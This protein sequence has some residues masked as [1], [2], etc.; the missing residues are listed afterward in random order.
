MWIT[1]EVYQPPN[2]VPFSPCCAHRSLS[3]T[4]YLASQ[5]LIAHFSGVR[6]CLSSQLALI[7]GCYLWKARG[8]VLCVLAVTLTQ[9]RPAS[10]LDTMLQMA[11]WV[12]MHR[13]YRYYMKLLVLCEGDYRAS[14]SITSVDVGS[15]Y[16][17]LS[18]SPPFGCQCSFT[19]HHLFIHIKSLISL[20]NSIYLNLL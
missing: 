12:W 19:A 10:P 4:T 6:N 16:S 7:G 17:A 1:R 11:T 8:V 18:M 3:F 15:D 9:Q 20:V 5:Q 2:P 14:G 13:Y